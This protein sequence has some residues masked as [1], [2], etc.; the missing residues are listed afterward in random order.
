M[1]RQEFIGWLKSKRLTGNYVGKDRVMFVSG[2]DAHR[3]LRHSFEVLKLDFKVEIKGD[4]P[5]S[6]RIPEFHL[7]KMKGKFIAIEKY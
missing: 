7:T 2:E 4:A 1:T 3:K 5:M 6:K